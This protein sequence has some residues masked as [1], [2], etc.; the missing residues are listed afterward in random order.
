MA[1]DAGWLILNPNE[2]Q[3]CPDCADDYWQQ[4]EL[5]ALSQ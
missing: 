5:E 3:L 4:M 2:S 1:E